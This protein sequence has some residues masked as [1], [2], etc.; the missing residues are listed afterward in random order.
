VLIEVWEC[1]DQEG[2]PLSVRADNMGN[3]YWATAAQLAHTKLPSA[4]TKAVVVAILEH[5]EEKDAAQAA[6]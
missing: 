5:R 1:G 6:V 2:V 3:G 4:I